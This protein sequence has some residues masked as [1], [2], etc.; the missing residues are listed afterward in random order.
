MLL[1][2]PFSL[3]FLTHL[4]VYFAQCFFPGFVPGR[5]A[6]TCSLCHTN[7]RQAEGSKPTLPSHLPS[8]RQR[9]P[10][11]VSHCLE[12]DEAFIFPDTRTAVAKKAY[13]RPK[14][15]FRRRVL[16]T[17]T[18]YLRLYRRH[19][20]IPTNNHCGLLLPLVPQGP[21]TQLV[22][23]QVSSLTEGSARR[24]FRDAVQ[25]SAGTEATTGTRIEEKPQ[26]QLRDIR[27]M[28]PE[29]GSLSTPRHPA[30]Y[31]L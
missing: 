8:L 13:P 16:R 25:L 6:G 15:C 24:P 5:S 22:L 10:K 27:W 18:R 31:T 21:L 4:V 9:S 30:R 2:S 23:N 12:R 19:Q 20:S 11:C 17:I 29:P 7:N 3:D 26:P 14:S 28:R 1:K